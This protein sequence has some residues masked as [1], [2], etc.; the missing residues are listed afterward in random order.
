MEKIFEKSTL[1]LSRIESEYPKFEQL[2]FEDDGENTEISLLKYKDKF[3]NVSFDM[4][5]SWLLRCARIFSQIWTQ[6]Q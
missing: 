5:K 3:D 1:F 6:S 2:Q 4:S